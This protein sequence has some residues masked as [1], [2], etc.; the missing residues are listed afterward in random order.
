MPIR[1]YAIIIVS[2]IV[3]HDLWHSHR[4]ER[5]IEPTFV[6]NVTSYLVI[7]YEYYKTCTSFILLS[8]FILLFKICIK[9]ELFLL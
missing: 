1:Q 4:G 8:T 7:F 9:N 3:F 5:G 2:D 6:A